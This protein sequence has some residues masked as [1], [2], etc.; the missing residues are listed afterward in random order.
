MWGSLCVSQRDPG[1]YSSPIR[2]GH[3][4]YATCIC[5]IKGGSV[6]EWLERRI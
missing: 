5:F 1:I 2:S 3:Y 6:A 4:S